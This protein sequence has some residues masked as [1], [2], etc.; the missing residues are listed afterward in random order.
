MNFKKLENISRSLANYLRHNPEK[1]GI[2]LDKNGWTDVDTLL[3]KLDIYF[4]ELEWIVKNNNKKRFGF[5]EDSTK[6]RAN[7]GHSIETVNVEY[8]K[9]LPDV[10]IL[11]HGTAIHLKDVILEEGL[12]K[13][14]RNHVH[15]SKDINTATNVALRKSKSIILFKVDASKMILDGLDVF[16]SE[17]NVYLSDNI[18]SKYITV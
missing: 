12:N 9:C 5:N 18:P 14:N 15:L 17:N 8:K 10:G 1:L 6:I 4:D 11:Y 3:D 16:I 7:Q 13:M 2:T